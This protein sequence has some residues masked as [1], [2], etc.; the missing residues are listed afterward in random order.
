[1]IHYLEKRHILLINRSTVEAH[2]GNY[3]PPANLLHEE[4]LDYIID[5]V[6]A[7]MFGEALYPTIADKA[8]IYFYNTICNHIFLDGNKRT[9]LEA[10]L[11]FLRLNACRLDKNL[12]KSELLDF[13]IKVASGESSLE[14]CRA[15]FARHV[16]TQ[17]L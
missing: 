15:W 2:G 4:N 1:M 7:E 17:R 3:T 13:T 10:A 9:G 12:P 14:E 6:E 16:V 8:A 11:C 5:A